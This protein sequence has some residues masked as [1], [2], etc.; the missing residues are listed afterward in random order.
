VKVLVLSAPIEPPLYVERQG[1]LITLGRGPDADVC[2]PDPTVSP[3]HATLKKR[4]KHY[5]LTDEGSTNG[6]ALSGASG[7]PPVWLSPGSPRIVEEGDRIR[8]GAVELE[9]RLDAEAEGSPSEDLGRD[10]VTASLAALNLSMEPEQVD[11]ALTELT[12]LEDEPMAAAAPAPAEPALDPAG[13]VTGGR[14]R[15]ATDLLVGG[16]ALVVLAVSGLALHFFVLT[17]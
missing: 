2:L 11:A 17:R 16:A 6:T 13:V 14:S 3:R 15:L 4:G 10:L 1:R 7:G 5:L 8:L 12:T 9:V